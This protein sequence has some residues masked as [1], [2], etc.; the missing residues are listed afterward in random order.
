MISWEQ[1][2]EQG[3]GRLR[4]FRLDGVQVAELLNGELIGR[5]GT[6][7]W[8]LRDDVT[9]M[10]VGI[11]SYVA[12]LECTSLITP[13]H[14]VQRCLVNVGQSDVPPSKR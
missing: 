4:I 3:I 8:D 7:T 5:S 11:G 9:R 1:P 12:V 6:A 14:H 13:E 2:I 10:P